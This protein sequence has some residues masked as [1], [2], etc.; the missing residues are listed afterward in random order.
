M[1]KRAVEAICIFMTVIL[2]SSLTPTLGAYFRNFSE[3]Y[4]GSPLF[5]ISLSKSTD[6]LIKNIKSTYVGKNKIISIPLSC[7]KRNLIIAKIREK[8]NEI[9]G[10]WKDLKS[11]VEMAKKNPQLFKKLEVFKEFFKKTDDEVD[12]EKIAG[13]I[14]PNCITFMGICLLLKLLILLFLLIYITEIPAPSCIIPCP[15]L[16]C[17]AQCIPTFPCF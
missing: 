6:G 2:A 13:K 11:A 16:I 17:T 12:P 15:T 4:Q 8:I 10:Y 5:T 3:K 9:P 14:Y 7:S 1:T